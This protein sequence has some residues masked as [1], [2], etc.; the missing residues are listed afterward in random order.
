MTVPNVGVKTTSENH[1]HT[2]AATAIAVTT[3]ERCDFGVT[4]H[5]YPT[6]IF[7]HE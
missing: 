6:K 2:T 1:A 5:L 7:L 3:S 4:A